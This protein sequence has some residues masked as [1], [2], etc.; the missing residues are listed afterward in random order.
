MLST[1]PDASDLVPGD[2]AFYGGGDLPSRIVEWATHSRF[3][4]CAV[5]IGHSQGRTQQ[6]EA[7][8]RGI[9]RSSIRDGQVL[10]VARVGHALPAR[11]RGLAWLA[12][13][14]GHPYSFWDIVSD[15]LGIVSDGRTPLLV[16]PSQYDC[17]SLATRFLLKAGYALPDALADYPDRCSPGDLAKALGVR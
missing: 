15:G 10:A 9:V 3:S 6:V 2:I 7:V 17:S 13:Q 14:L 12:A 5:V 8:R 11:A 16:A 1:A 4:H